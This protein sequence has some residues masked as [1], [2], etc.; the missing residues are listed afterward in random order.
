MRRIFLL[1]FVVLAAGTLFAGQGK[2]D[3]WGD[4]LKRYGDVS[5]VNPGAWATYRMHSDKQDGTPETL[6]MKM[7]CVGKEKVDGEDGLW[8]ETEMEMAEPGEKAAKTMIMKMLVVGDPAD[9][10]SV[11]KMIIQMG[12]QP[13]M[14]LPIPRDISEQTD[15]MPEIED[16]GM[17]TIKVPAGTFKCHHLRST[18]DE[19]HI[20]EIYLDKKVS[21]YGI[22]KMQM[23]EGRL[24]LVKHGATGA[25]SKITSEPSS[26]LNLHNM[27]KGMM[28]EEDMKD[29][30]RKA[31]ERNEKEGK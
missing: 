11:K 29:A 7:S 19:G 4:L 15:E 8:L 30:L 3:V 21:M 9:Q 2:G 17:E 31:Q 14:S 28:K 22:V 10:Q 26:P 5:N 18:D 12:E 27:M 16:L 24:E 23:E 6:D 20:M 25:V 13:P 1:V